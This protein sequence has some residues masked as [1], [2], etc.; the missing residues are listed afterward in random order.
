MV[1][2]DSLAGRRHPHLVAEISANHCGS[3]DKAKALLH[4][5][6]HA[7]ADAVKLQ[8]YTADSMTIRCQREDFLIAHGN[9]RGYYLHDLYGEASTP[10]EWHPELFRYGAELGLEVFS[11]PF[12]IDSVTLLESLNCP[13]YK[14]ASFELT[15]LNL[16][17]AVSATRKPIVLSTGMALESEIGDAVS[18]ARDSGASKIVLLHCISSYPAP[19]EEMN[20]RRIISLSRRFDVSVGLS[21]HSLDHLSSITATALGATVIEKHFTLDRRA[22]GH[23]STF[24][25]E[26][27]EFLELSIAIAKVWKG[28][29]SGQMIPTDS[30]MKSR[31][32]RR[33][34]YFVRD[35]QAGETV[36][37]ESIRAI[38]PGY[39]LE[40]KRIGEV[41]GRKLKF[42]IR[43]GDRVTLDCVC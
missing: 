16:I 14:I 40:P 33:S 15:D 2:N 42:N 13:I 34:L 7:G 36:T 1:F 25:V 17:A 35:M 5:A 39:G 30:E 32:F 29:G 19:I 37:A 27:S 20:L 23:D 43:L 18:V 24:S 3:L 6:K 38:R 12:D 10:Y 4:A 11:T 8:T 26:P 22:G 31:Q 21:D 28:L 9:W 41:L